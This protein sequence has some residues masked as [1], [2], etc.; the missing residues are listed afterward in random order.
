MMRVIN[1]LLILAVIGLSVGLYDIK[2]K[3]EEAVRHARQL[4]QRIASEQE[5]IRVLRAE[6]SYLNQPERLQELAS[7]YTTLQPLG[8]GQIGSFEDVPMPHMADDFYVP[9]GRQPLGGYAGGIA[10]GAPGSTIQ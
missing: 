6:W 9:S 7:R 2:Y 8:A 1:F 4:E 3:A 5:A 10:P